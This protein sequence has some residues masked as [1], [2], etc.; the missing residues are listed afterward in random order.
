MLHLY[1]LLLENKS[2]LI[3]H[4][5]DYVNLIQKCNKKP[6][7][8]ISDFFIKVQKTDRESEPNVKDDILNHVLP[9]MS[10]ETT[11]NEVVDINKPSSSRSTKDADKINVNS[12]LPDCWSTKQ[13]DE[14]KEK[15]GGLLV[16]GKKIGCDICTKVE[17]VNVKVAHVPKE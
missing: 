14:F 6:L 4:F 10:S 7:Q 11:E 15:Y 17:S 16:I 9:S 8:E 2:N 13:A 12:D 5:S 3:F 1:T